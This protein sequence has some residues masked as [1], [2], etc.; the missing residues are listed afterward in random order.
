MWNGPTALARP[1]YERTM[2]RLS[3]GVALVQNGPAAP[4]RPFRGFYGW[5]IKQ[6]KAKIR[7]GSASRERA[8]L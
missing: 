4:R 2:T 5:G 6:A 3:A 1:S 7:N 8:I